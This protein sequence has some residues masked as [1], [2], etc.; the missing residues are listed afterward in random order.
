MEGILLRIGEVAERAGQ[1]DRARNAYRRLYVEFQVSR[2]AEAAEHALV[3]LDPRSDPSVVLPAGDLAGELARAQRLF[4]ARRFQPAWQAY[5]R[6]ATMV[7][8]DDRALAE[9]RRSECDYHLRRFAAARDGLK[10]LPGGPSRVAEARYY[11]LGTAR[12]LN[13]TTI[14]IREVAALAEDFPDDRWTEA[15]LDSLATYYIIEDLDADADRV[16]RDMLRRFPDG[17]HAERAAWRVGWFAYRDGR[18]TE[19]ARL[20]AEAAASMPRADRRP[21]WLYWSGRAHEQLGE[22]EMAAARYRL[23]IIDY[24]NSYYGRLATARLAAADLPMI[25]RE[26]RVPTPPPPPPPTADAIRELMAHGLYQDALREVRFARQAF[27]DTPALQATEAWLRGTVGRAQ[28]SRERFD[29]VRGAINLMKRAYPQYLAAGGEQLPAAMLGVLFPMEYWPLIERHA[30]AND[31]DPYLVAA[32]VS[33]ESTFTPDI[34]SGANAVGLMQLVPGTAKR[35]ARKLGLTFN[36]ALLRSPDANLRLGTAYFR[37]LL[38]RFGA[39]H[40]AL[41]GYNAGESRVDAWIAERPGLD[42]QDE[43][44]DDIPYPETQLYVKKILSMAEDY[45]RLYGGGLIAPGS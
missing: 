38:D 17:E 1:L 32:L 11:R 44:I 28:E 25:W 34:R 45:R 15:A 33:Q 14:Y 35:Y 22:I 21:A 5:N 2:E 37:E 8:G 20:F 36:S 40:L 9:L 26:G 39:V 12:G 31:L 41:A 29:N 42:E 4:D 6:I 18:F 24:Q 43:F 3:R 10:T 16:F 23:A 13:E 7:T 19:T 30:A 27:I